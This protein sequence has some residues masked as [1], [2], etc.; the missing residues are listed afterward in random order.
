MSL[1]HEEVRGQ[2]EA[3]TEDMESSGGEEVVA[4]P[5]QKVDVAKEQKKTLRDSMV[6]AM[7]VAVLL[8]TFAA[9]V[10]TSIFVVSQAFGGEDD[11]P[12]L[13]ALN[14]TLKAGKR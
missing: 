1:R 5:P 6:P 8:L 3:L 11:K 13:T 10:G 4:T 7:V 14:A 2:R 9:I 12:S